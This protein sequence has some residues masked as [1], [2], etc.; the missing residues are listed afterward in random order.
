MNPT[1]ECIKSSDH[2]Y[3]ILMENKSLLAKNDCPNAGLMLGMFIKQV[4]ETLAERWSLILE[5]KV[6]AASQMVL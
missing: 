4:R 5:N 1:P 2:F 3:S 6:Q